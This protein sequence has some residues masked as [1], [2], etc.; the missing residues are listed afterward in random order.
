[1]CDSKTIHKALNKFIN[2]MNIVQYIQNWNNEPWLNT[3]NY[4]LWQILLFITGMVLWL[5]CYID[6]IR[7]IRKHQQLVIPFGTVLTNYGWEISC[8][9]FFLPDMGKLLA[10]GY[11][12]WMLFDTFIFISTFKYAFKQCRIPEIKGNIH[13]YLIIGI[14]VSFFTQVT[15]IVFYDLPMAP[16]S[17]NIINIY[18]SIAFIYLLYVPGQVNAPLTGWSKFLGTAIINVMFYTKYPQNYCLVT[19]ALSCAIFDLLYIYL[20]YK[21]KNTI[22]ATL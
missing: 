18:M 11:W 3:N 21:Q 4:E 22:I 9:F 13:L 15:F 20:I 10:V 19:L 6:V 8:A 5:V 14:L 7:N 1:M 12:A 16:V 17:A 2:I